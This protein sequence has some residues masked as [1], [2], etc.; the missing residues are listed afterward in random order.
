MRF[1]MQFIKRHTTKARNLISL[2]CLIQQHVPQF[3]ATGNQFSEERRK[4]I[5]WQDQQIVLRVHIRLEG[6]F[7]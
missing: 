1:D 2:L 6:V 7:W 5:I 3:S 4:N